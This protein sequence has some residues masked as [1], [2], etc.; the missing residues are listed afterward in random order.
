MYRYMQI[1]F[2]YLNTFKPYFCKG[3]YNRTESTSFHRFYPRMHSM[4][5]CTTIFV[6]NTNISTQ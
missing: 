4:L 3:G 2:E 5:Q 1:W 6:S